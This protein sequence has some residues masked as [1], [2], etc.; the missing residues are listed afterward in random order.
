MQ[1]IHRAYLQV[2]TDLNA[3]TEVLSWFDQFNG[4]PLSYQT[5]LQCQLALAEGFTNAVRHA[6]QG[7]PLELPID[8][9]VTVL[10]ACLEIRI[11]D[12]GEPFNLRQKLDSLPQEMDSDAEGGRGL[13]LMQRI[14]DSLSYTRTSDNRNC[15]LI[16]KHYPEP[17]S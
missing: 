15:L 16:V 1:P 8:I 6:H 14:A 2:N 3:L 7:Q 11:W 13:K 12:Q 10:S 17:D 9:E 5:W 4:P